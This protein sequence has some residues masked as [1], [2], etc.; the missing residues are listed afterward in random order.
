MPRR[1][2]PR[3]GSLQFWP[4][5]RAEKFLPSV[6][7]KIIPSDSSKGFKGIIGYKAGMASAYVKDNTPDS[8]T[9]D[10]R[11]TIPVTIIECP[12]MK[13][14]SARFYKNKKVAKEILNNNPEKE[15][16]KK[17]KLPK[18]TSE[19]FEK[20][21]PEDYDDVTIIAYSQVKKTNLKKKPDL[22]EIGLHDKGGVKEK[23]D[24]IKENLGKE[25]SVTDIFDNNQL[26]DLRGI[27]RGKGFQ[28]PLKRFGLSLKSH[29]SE[30][31]RRRP[32]SLAPWHP[33][34]VT[35]RTAMAGQ[36]GMHTRIHYNQT[37]ISL[38]KPQD[39]KKGLTG[40][41]G[42]GDIKTDYII[43]TGSVQGPSKRQVIITSPLR[44]SKKQTK[45]NYE[46]I[47]LR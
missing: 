47:E 2:A 33:A 24:F 7:W 28:G 22:T 37:L 8:R 23:I 29:K 35:F 9:K 10:K 41:K 20:I 11:I 25:I 15:L 45:K 5:K 42:Y 32:G 26:V 16:K 17:I 14:F 18:K 3:K 38:G 46:L 19:K 30:K 13:I 43:V 31:G 44:E 36:M 27:T 6:N 1:K 4:R 12:K 34:R 40:I 21:N 39:L